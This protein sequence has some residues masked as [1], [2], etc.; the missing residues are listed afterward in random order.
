MIEKDSKWNLY[1][2]LHAQKTPNLAAFEPKNVGLA[3]NFQGYS[4]TR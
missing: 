2:V 1:F 4:H 3:D